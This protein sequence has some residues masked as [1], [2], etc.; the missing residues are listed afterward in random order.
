MAVGCL[1]PRTRPCAPG[2]LWGLCE[3]LPWRPP[4]A[5]P[6][7]LDSSPCPHPA[8]LAPPQIVGPIQVARRS[9]MDMNG[10]V[11]NT[12]YLAWAMETVPSDIYH[13]AHLYQVRRAVLAQ[14][15]SCRPA[16]PRRGSDG[17]CDA[18]SCQ[19]ATPAS[20][21]RLG[22]A[23]HQLNPPCTLTHTCPN[24]RPPPWQIEIDFKAECHGG[25]LVESLAGRCGEPGPAPLPA[26]LGRLPWVAGSWTHAPISTRC[27]ANRSATLP[28]PAAGTHD[29]LSQNGAG[30]QPLSFVHVL[31]RCQGEACTE[32]VRSRTTWRAL[33][34]A[35]DLSD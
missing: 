16:G 18:W 34:S 5:R 8:L 12:T 23:L 13:G 28:L 21:L 6:T 3:G 26:P 32:L 9:D 15:P 2:R 11:N 31:R 25:D 33:D 10:H 19:G 27:P 7:P 1:P 17:T 30:P 14:G 35:S 29:L 4:P 22:L 20:S 24:P